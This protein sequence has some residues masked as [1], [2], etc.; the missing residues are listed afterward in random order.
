MPDLKNCPFCG[1]KAEIRYTGDGAGPYGY[2]SN[3]LMKNKPGYVMCKKCYCRTEVYT[4]VAYAM[5]KWNRRF[6]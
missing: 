6:G 1:G 3:I 2:T 4:D 5:K